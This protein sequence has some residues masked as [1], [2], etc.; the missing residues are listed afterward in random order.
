MN[1]DDFLEILYANSYKTP[2]EYC[3]VELF[4]AYLER[5]LEDKEQPTLTIEDFKKAVERAVFEYENSCHSCSGLGCNHCL[6]GNQ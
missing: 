5:Q 2:H 3:S 1:E 6:G 4:D